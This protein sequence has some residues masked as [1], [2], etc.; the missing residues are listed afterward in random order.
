MLRIKYVQHTVFFEIG[1]I[2]AFF[3]LGLIG[4]LHHEMWSDELQA[5]L[6]ARDSQSIVDLF[7]NLRYEGHP[8][9]WHL[10][11]YGLSRISRNPVIMQFFHLAIATTSISL[12][13]KFAPFSKLHKILFTFSYFPFYEYSIISRNYALGVLLVF[14]FCILYT[15]NCNYI[16][17][18]TVLALLANTNLYAAMLAIA[19]GATLILENLVKYQFQFSA[20]LKN[21]CL[22]IGALILSASLILMIVQILPPPDRSFG[23]I[24]PTESSLQNIHP[25]EHNFLLSLFN[26]LSNSIKK[27]IRSFSITLNAYL[28]IPNVFVSEIWNSN[29]SLAVVLDS[30]SKWVAIVRFSISITILTTIILCF[31]QN[32]LI[33]FFYSFGNLEIFLFTFAYLKNYG[34]VRHHGHLFLIFVISLWLLVDQS[35]SHSSENSAKLMSKIRKNHGFGEKFSFLRCE[36]F[37]K[38]IN[39]LSVQ[40]GYES[41]KKLIN[42]LFTL[43]L[44]VH[45]IATL[46][47]F[48]VDIRQPFS[49]SKAVSEYIYKHQMQDMLIVGD[50]A[51][52]TTPLSG[53]LNK[54]LYYPEIGSF[55]T[56]ATHKESI[57][58][59]FSDVINQVVDLEQFNQQG[60][61]LVL[62]YDLG[63]ISAY[64]T[65]QVNIVETAQFQQ[66]MVKFDKYF[67]YKLQASN[68]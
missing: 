13:I 21:R 12:F 43:I 53:Y 60:A 50:R 32:P 3:I 29:I 41:S 39:H 14:L 51:I 18:F 65:K 47:L 2:S 20:L 48:T 54:S 57:V 7:Q 15:R 19:L 42:R 1:L 30:L 67:L 68:R 56:F 26:E 35:P 25:S 45:C 59:N 16:I 27:L 44:C 40:I 58:S 63:D 8:G 28:P 66:S 36:K 5:W 23:Q 38:L 17:L 9:L 62:T 10:C 37:K 22:A 6:I 46:I 31:R 34:S 33:L 24:L 61:L 55:G 4:V 11:L 49:A 52:F 64:S